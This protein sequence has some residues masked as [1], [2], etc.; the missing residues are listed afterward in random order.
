MFLQRRRLEVVD[1][2]DAVAL[3]KQVPTKIGV[4]KA[5]PITTV[6]VTAG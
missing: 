3:R 2:D 1:A 4:E 5:G 6:V